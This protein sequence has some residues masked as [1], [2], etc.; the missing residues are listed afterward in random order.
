MKNKLLYKSKTA[1]MLSGF[2]TFFFAIITVLIIHFMI[3]HYLLYSFPLV[4]ISPPVSH[5]PKLRTDRTDRSSKSVRFSDQVEILNEAEIPK[6]IDLKSELLNYVQQYQETP[7]SKP[8]DSVSSVADMDNYDELSKFFDISNDDNY[9]F[10]ET[11]TT[12]RDLGLESVTMT[13]DKFSKNT[14]DINQAASE[15]TISKNQWGYS[16]ERVMNGATMFGDVMG[17]DSYNMDDNFACII[18]D[19]GG[20][21][22]S[23]K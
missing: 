20:N 12:E 4:S 11:P 17:F 23:Q 19:K 22:S 16:N 18:D 1:S 3:K 8:S 13:T 21:N 14:V 9:I 2:R 15:N 7:D 5:V 6:E 10:E